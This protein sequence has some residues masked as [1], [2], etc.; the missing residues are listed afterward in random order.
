MVS[1]SKLKAWACSDAERNSQVTVTTEM[2]RGADS[3][4]DRA[5]SQEIATDLMGKAVWR[6]EESQKG[7]VQRYSHLYVLWMLFG[8]VCSVLI[9]VYFVQVAGSLQCWGGEPITAWRQNKRLVKF[10]ALLGWPCPQCQQHT[11][12]CFWSNLNRACYLDWGGKGLLFCI[13]HGREFC[14]F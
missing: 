8:F 13:I 9:E 11:S 12:K 2:S 5:R 6:P 1:F 3:T 7:W 4:P 10:S 14:L